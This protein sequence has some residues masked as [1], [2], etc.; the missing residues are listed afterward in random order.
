MRH[1]AILSP[2]YFRE[3]V[4]GRRQDLPSNSLRSLLRVAEVPYTWAVN[5]RNLRYDQGHNAVHRMGVPV[6]SVG[7]LTLGGT[8]KTPMVEWLA[9][10]FL[11][12]NI[13]VGL[14]SRGYGAK[15]NGPNDEAKELAWKLPDVP[16]VQ[17]PDRVAAARQ[18]IDEHGCQAIVLD[19][20]F[21]HRRIYRDLDILLID[22]LEPTGFGHVFPRGTLHASR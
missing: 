19:D 1:P 17:N 21:Q 3:V 7:N 20:A 10:W 11:E 14:V 5:R 9:R 13:K 6:V 8:G 16:H 2:T 15:Q 22:A 18:A 12:R 4:S